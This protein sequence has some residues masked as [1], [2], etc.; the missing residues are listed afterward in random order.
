M[1]L[2][3]KKDWFL[4]KWRETSKWSVLL[5]VIWLV[6]GILSLAI[7]A[8]KID[9]N[10]DYYY[11]TTGRYIEYENQQRQYENQQK[12]QNNGNNNYYNPYPTCKWYQVKCR[13]AQHYYRA[14]NGDQN[15]MVYTPNWYSFIGGGQNSEENR[16]FY[17]EMGISYNPDEPSGAM[18]FVHSWT[19]IMF[20]GLLV[21]GTFVLLTGRSVLGLIVLCAVFAQFSL[22]QIVLCGQGVISSDNRQIED[23]IYGWWGQAG[24][25]QVY[26]DFGIFLFCTVFTVIFTIQGIVRICMSRRV[27]TSSKLDDEVDHEQG[28]SSPPAVYRNLD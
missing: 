26:M 12:Q 23:T 11:S 17:E 5:S 4:N 9:G 22:L 25:A 19:I 21:Y 18:K 28:L 15:D 10:K 14:Q 1:R 27:G 16:R 13:Q 8:G 24:V 7:P 6:A 20:L 2:A 3:V